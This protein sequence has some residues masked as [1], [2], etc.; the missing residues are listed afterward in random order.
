MTLRTKISSKFTPKITLN[1]GKSNKEITKH[2][3]VTIEKVLPP[4]ILAK[5]KK[6]VNII[7]KYFQ[8]N[9]LSAEPK[10]LTMSYA[11]ASKQ[12]ANTSEVLK[13][14]EAFPAINAKKIDQ[15]NNIIKGNPKPKSHIQMTTKSPF[16]KQVIVLMS[17]ENN[18][19]FMKN[20]TTH[21]ANINR[22]LRN[23]KSEVLVD[24]ICSDPLRIS[25][26][27]NKIS[28]QSDLQIIDQYVKNS[29]DIN[30]LQVDEPHLPQSKLY[31]KNI[32]ISYFPYSN[33]QDCLTS[34]DVETILKQNQIF[35]NV[36]L[37]FKPRVI[38][39]LPKLDMSIIWIDIWDVQSS[40]KA[41]G[42]I[43]QCFNVSKYITTIRGANMNLGVP[44][45]KNCWK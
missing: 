38:K 43:N 22:Y 12:T 11:Q 42:L 44:Q 23:A 29:R 36:N 41:K 33:T 18:N 16:R 34:S 9:K 25:I 6:E 17:S 10:E 7:S 15:I 35:N 14:K 45:C 27:T 1:S 31:L 4:S 28:L 5:S 21:V 13:I 40:N 2:I 39:V 37:A 30:A 19:N 8:S 3:P 32:G 24:Y 26:I 20:S